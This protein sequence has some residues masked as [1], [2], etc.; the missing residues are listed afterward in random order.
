[1]RILAVLAAAVLVLAPPPAQ[2]AV[3]VTGI[4]QDAAGKPIPVAIVTV[5]GDG[6]SV[7]AP[8]DIQG[9]FSFT[10]D[11]PDEVAISVDAKGYAERRQSVRLGEI[12]EARSPWCS[13]GSPSARR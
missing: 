1:M 3:R 6:K 9:R 4:V 12:P 2:A 7:K 10:W 5:R 13:R 8:S 11:G